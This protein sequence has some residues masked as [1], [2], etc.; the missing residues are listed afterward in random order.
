MTHNKCVCIEGMK[1]DSVTSSCIQFSETICSER[2]QFFNANEEICEDFKVCEEGNE[3][4]KVNNMCQVPIIEV[5]T[6]STCD[7]NLTF[8]EITNQCE[9]KPQKS[10]YGLIMLMLMMIA[11]GILYVVLDDKYFCI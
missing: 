8:N 4:D 1:F 2:K 5:D 6:A 10:K 3:L 7:D 11:G 9:K